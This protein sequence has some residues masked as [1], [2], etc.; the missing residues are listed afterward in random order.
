[1]TLDIVI[2]TDNTPITQLDGLNPNAVHWLRGDPNNPEKSLLIFYQ[3]TEGSL[4]A[5]YDFLSGRYRVTDF[6]VNPLSGKVN[7]S[8]SN[9]GSI[10]L[11]RIPVMTDWEISM[12]TDKFDY[13]RRASE[14]ESGELH[15]DV[16]FVPHAVDKDLAR[17]EILKNYVMKHLAKADYSVVLERERRGY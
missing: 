1:M 14:D 11:D 3:R 8:G 2:R 5:D 12:T 10:P 9:G 15:L 4:N 6:T 17:N 7:A 13:F 16:V